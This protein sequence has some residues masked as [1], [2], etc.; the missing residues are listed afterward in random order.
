MGMNLTMAGDY[1]IRA[2]IHLASLPEGQSALR[3]EI[4][5]TQHIPLS[6]MAKIL[7]RLVQARLLRSA[8]GVNGGFALAQPAS[9]ITL[10]DV[11]EAIEGPISLT[12]CASEDRSCAWSQDCPASLVWP[13]VQTSIRDTL[14]GTTLESLVGAQRRNGRIAFLRADAED[15]ERTQV[16]GLLQ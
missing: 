3:S 11:V 10:L 15:E 2:M 8:R 16:A 5:R 12:P 9:A 14:R 13:D 4:S 1:A 6:F 7:R